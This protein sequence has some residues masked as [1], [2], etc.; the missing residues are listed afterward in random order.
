MNSHC[1]VA[2]LLILVGCSS[3]SSPGSSNPD[4]SGRDGGGPPG[5]GASDAAVDSASDASSDAGRL[6]DGQVVTPPVDAGGNE[7]SGQSSDA[8]GRGQG[9]A[10]SG[11]DGQVVNPPSDASADQASGQ[12]PDAGGNGPDGGGDSGQPCVSNPAQFTYSFQDYCQPLETRVTNLLSLLTD[13][14]AV[15]MLTEYQPAVARLGIPAFSTYTEGIHGLGSSQNE[16]T[17]SLLA[18]QFPQAS[19]LGETWDSGDDAP[20]GCRRGS[21]SARLLREVQRDSRQPGDP[22]R[23][24]ST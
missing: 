3:S 5:Q 12:S 6:G 14:E 11:G 9:D 17:M 22:G 10:G 4:A 19:G 20:G 1:T 18:T 24:S 2:L 15:S 8:G 16:P 21:R 13:A 7:A 23:R